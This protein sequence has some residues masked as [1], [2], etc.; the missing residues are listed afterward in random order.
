MGEKSELASL[1]DLAI[2]QGG[3]HSQLMTGMYEAVL[4]EYRRLN[5]KS[6]ADA[7][8]LLDENSGKVRV[9]SGDEDAT[10]T[11]WGPEA[12]RIARQTV[13]DQLAYGKPEGKMRM[14]G[15]T[16]GHKGSSGIM[17]GLINLFFWGYNLYFALVIW[18]WV[19]SVMRNLTSWGVFRGLLVI[20]LAM[21]PVAAMGV[22]VKNK[23]WKSSGSLLKLF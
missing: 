20:V 21:T 9:F 23:L 12:A 5:P 3:S 11:G 19:L 4:A 8:V 14:L 13:I 1:I 2:A 6:P 16:G 18:L 7:T 10:P 15:E 22:V 17:T